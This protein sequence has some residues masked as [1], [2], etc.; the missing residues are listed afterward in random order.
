[1]NWI[2]TLPPLVNVPRPNFMVN[3]YDKYEKIKQI[4][5]FSFC[6]KILLREINNLE[7]E[8]KNLEVYMEK[9]KGYFFNQE[10]YLIQTL[11]Y[12][13]SMYYQAF[14]LISNK[15]SIL[16]WHIRNYPPC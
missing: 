4:M 1:M 11:N 13:I 16:W 3:E 7:S 8:I 14:N 5:Y 9:N 10:Y 2:L 15:I 12:K 6:K